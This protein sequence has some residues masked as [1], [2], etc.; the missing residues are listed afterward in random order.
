MNKIG[1]SVT[2]SK[3]SQSEIDKQINELSCDSSKLNSQ[4]NKQNN[5]FKRNSKSIN[6]GSL[7]EE[8][9]KVVKDV[10]NHAENTVSRG[11][12]GIEI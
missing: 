7:V 10:Y 12:H 6:T 2:G 4:N 11:I 1:G 3:S 9:V 5:L 8:I